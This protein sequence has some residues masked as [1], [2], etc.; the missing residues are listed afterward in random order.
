MSI[1]KYLIITMN[2]TLFSVLSGCG[3]GGSSSNETV[4]PS[5]TVTS[6]DLSTYT[7][8]SLTDYQKYSLAYMWNEERLAHD[9]Y[10]NLYAINPVT[11][12]ER[13]ATNSE[14]VHID[15]VKD[16]V[17]AYDINITNL[18]DY[19]EHY[20][21]AELEAMPSGIYGIPAIQD[22]YDEL[23]AYGVASSQ[24]SLEVGCKVEVVDVN[25]LDIY[26]TQADTNEALIDTF[27]ILRNGSYQHYWAFDSGL[28][29]LGITDGCCSLGNE[30]CKT[31]NEYPQ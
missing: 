11:Q 20:S 29:N 16:L 4:T 7:L 21:Q 1:I 26:I 19:K 28:K 18:V 8:Q 22:L 25:D 13:I 14:T 24:T 5:Q 17:E 12:L 15:L 2:A 3:G 6:I 31:T 23:Y 30:Y 9:I 27:N 10:L